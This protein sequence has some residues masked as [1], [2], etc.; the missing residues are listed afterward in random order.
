V[1]VL[2]S[3]LKEELTLAILRK[4]RDSLMKLTGFEYVTEMEGIKPFRKPK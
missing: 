2:K 3:L 4:C 1:K